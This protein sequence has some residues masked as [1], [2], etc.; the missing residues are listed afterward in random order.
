MEPET[1]PHFYQISFDN[2]NKTDY[3]SLEDQRYLQEWLA[4]VGYMKV[5][6]P[7]IIEKHEDLADVALGIEKRCGRILYMVS[8]TGASGGQHVVIY[9][10]ADLLWD[11]APAG[12]GLIGPGI[13]GVYWFTFLMPLSMRWDGTLPP[14]E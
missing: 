3:E 8:A 5:D 11:P 13:D 7:Y 12:G 6:L 14:E 10:G 9:K 2:G 1:V 4:S